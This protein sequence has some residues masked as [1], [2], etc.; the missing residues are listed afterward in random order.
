MSCGGR[1]ET[2]GGAMRGA[3]QIWQPRATG[4]HIRRGLALRG[5]SEVGNLPLGSSCGGDDRGEAHNGGVAASTFDSDGSSHRWLPSA[6][7]Q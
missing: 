3:H 4:L 2:C 6:A 7:N 5:W 1:T